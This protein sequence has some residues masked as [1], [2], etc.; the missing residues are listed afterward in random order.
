MATIAHL[1]AS[2]Q[3]I[4]NSALESKLFL[5]GQGQLTPWPQVGS[6][7]I[8]NSFEIIYLSLLPEE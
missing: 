1:T 7:Q 5:I 8:S 2:H 4:L 3:N 6:S